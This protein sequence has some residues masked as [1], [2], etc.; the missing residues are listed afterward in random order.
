MQYGFWPKYSTDHALINLTECIRQS[1]D[2]GSFACGIFVD[3]H[4][5]FDTV[6]H[7]IL[8]HK[9]EYYGIW[10]K[11]ND[12]FK[13]YLSDLEQFVS[14]SG[15]DSDSMPVDCALPQGSVL[16]L[17]LSLI[18]VNDL[19]NQFST[20]RCITLLMIQK[21]FSYKQVCKKTK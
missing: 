21:S 19:H 13:S 5:T 11:C 17:L 18:Y 8:L 6:Y 10:G 20:A 14:I 1:L 9:L 16:E 4:K 2:E 7:K 3:L 12:W 15:Y